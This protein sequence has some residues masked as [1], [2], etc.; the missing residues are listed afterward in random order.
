MDKRTF[1]GLIEACEP[2]IKQAIDAMREYH[3]AQ[4]AGLPDAEIER[5]HLLAESLSSCIRLSASGHGRGARQRS[6]ASPLGPM[7]DIAPRQVKSGRPYTPA[8]APGGW[9]ALA[10]FTTPRSGLEF[11]AFGWPLVNPGSWLATCV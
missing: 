1:M 11:L 6:S 9:L 2:L 5:L 7:T 3:D 10:V 4:A 8:F